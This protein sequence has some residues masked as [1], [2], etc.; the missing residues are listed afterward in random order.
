MPTYEF[1]CDCGLVY[2]EHRS[3]KEGPPENPTCKCGEKMRRLY[4]P[5]FILKG[6]G[7][8]GKDIKKS[9]YQHAQW[10]EKEQQKQQDE[11]SDQVLANEV[12]KVRRKGS[13]AVEQYQKEHPDSYKRYVKNM[14]EKGIKGK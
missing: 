10:K 3:I 9:S 4:S 6:E 8:A 2:Q 12:L 14:R 13:K 5:N 7:W 1:E 11:K